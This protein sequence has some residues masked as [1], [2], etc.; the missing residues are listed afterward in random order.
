M[1]IFE[2]DYF[3]IQDEESC[4]FLFRK[5]YVE[6]YINIRNIKSAIIDSGDKIVVKDN[7]N[8]T[9]FYF[10]ISSLSS[11]KKHYFSIVEERENELK[12]IF[13]IEIN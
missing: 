9:I 5:E 12:T 10:T 8:Q 2:D 6:K 1:T 7:N 4:A 13:T 3:I 11:K